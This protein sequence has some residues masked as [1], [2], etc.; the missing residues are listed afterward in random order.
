RLPENLQ[1]HYTV[2]EVAAFSRWYLDDY[3]VL[4][5]RNRYGLLVLASARGS[6]WKA[7]SMYMEMPIMQA[8]LASLGPATLANLALILLLCMLLG[9]QLWRTLRAAAHGIDALA[10]GDAVRLPEKGV[11]GALAHQLNAA[12]QRL[13]RQ[14]RLIARRD[15][16]RT[17]WVAGV[18]HDIRTPLAVIVGYAEQLEADQALSAVQRQKAATIGTQALK[19][20]ALIADLNLTSKLQYNAQPLRRAR[21]T[22]GPLLR[23]AVTAFCNSNAGASTAELEMTSDAETAALLVDKALFARALDNLLGNSA[24]HNP[25]G[26]HIVVSAALRPTAAGQRL[27]IMVTDDGVGYPPAVLARLSNRPE[28]ASE[29]MREPASEQASEQAGEPANENEGVGAGAAPHILGLHLVEQIFA[30]HGGQSIF[31]QNTPTGAKAI[32]WLPLA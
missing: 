21:C 18:S 3:P 29:P 16:A 17:S 28:P 27:E 24:R 25:G 22:A 6:I 14:N 10:E 5:Y 30:A 20:K 11:A 1:K 26:C 2:G 15:N 23:E 19:I 12:S 9:W 32:L 4:C 8:I 7:S 31:A 13:Q